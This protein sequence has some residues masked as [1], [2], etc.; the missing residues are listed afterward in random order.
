MKCLTRIAVLFYVLVVFILSVFMLLAALNK[1]NVEHLAQIVQFIYFDMSSRIMFGWL[2]VAMIMIT[3]AYYRMFVLNS[4]AD[5]II[6][7]DN[8]SGRVSVSLTALEDIVR[9]TIVKR[10]EIKDAR[11]DMK[12]HRKTLITKVRLILCSEVNIPE[13]TSKIQDVVKNKIHNT[14]GIAE[15]VDITIYV[16]KIIPGKVKEKLKDE[17]PE[18]EHHVD[19]AIPFQGYRA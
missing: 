11:I 5:N 15:K 14:I 8:P 12:V 16:G 10:A 19:P 17:A 7:F 9:R 2:A 3:I 6:A 1:L 13:L 4:Y 18:E